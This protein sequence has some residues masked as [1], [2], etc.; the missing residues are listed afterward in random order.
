MRD[1]SFYT[2]ASELA[3][4]AIVLAMEASNRAVEALSA[5]KNSEHPL[6]LML[7]YEKLKCAA[8]II[9]ADG[10]EGK[11]AAHDLEKA[12]ADILRI[13]NPK[14]G[15][16]E[17]MEQNRYMRETAVE[18]PMA[19]CLY[20]W[21]VTGVPEYAALEFIADCTAYEYDKI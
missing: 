10:E 1:S 5:M 12:A 8:S 14:R 19:E 11:E 7:A 16:Y 9:A 21:S 6:E 2:A 15:V 17:M 18:L 3:A 20:Q 4:S 13:R